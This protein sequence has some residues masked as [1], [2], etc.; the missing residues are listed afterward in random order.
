MVGKI[1]G[2]IVGAQAA[3]SEP[4][5]LGGTGGA[6]LGAAVPMVL[7]RFGPLGLVAVAVGGYALKRYTE[8]PAKSVKR[9]AR[10]PASRPRAKRAAA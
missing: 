5:G 9:P 1:L 4:G 7:R 3:K 6:L 8:K 2:A 10:R